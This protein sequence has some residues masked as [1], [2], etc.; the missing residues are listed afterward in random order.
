[1]ILPS[2]ET[3]L[4]FIF[5]VIHSSLCNKYITKILKFEVCTNVDNLLFILVYMYNNKVLCGNIYK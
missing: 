5:S 4:F 1:M 3:I 2:V